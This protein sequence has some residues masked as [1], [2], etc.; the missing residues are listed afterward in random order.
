[1]PYKPGGGDKPQLYDVNSGEYIR[2]PK[3]EE[4]EKNLVLNKMFGI[5]TG[6]PIA[7]PVYGVHDLDYC[8]LFVA[9]C[10]NTKNPYIDERKITKYLLIHQEKD[11]K[12]KL[13]NLIGYSSENWNE[14]EQ[15]IIKGTTFKIKSKIKLNPMT[16]TFATYT[17]IYD[18]NCNKYRQY[19]SVWAIE[20]DFSLR[21]VTLKKGELK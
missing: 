7:Y 14:L 16:C 1:M 20:K 15:Q 5:D 8:K 3:C 18:K 12:S 13:M 17:N 10:L 21:F 19:I 9:Y 11:D 6:V 2:N 4:D